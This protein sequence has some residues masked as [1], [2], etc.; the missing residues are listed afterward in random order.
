MPYPC[1]CKTHECKWPDPDKV[2]IGSCKVVDDCDPGMTL[3]PFTGGETLF[4]IVT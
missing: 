1:E 4:E 3:N 2:L